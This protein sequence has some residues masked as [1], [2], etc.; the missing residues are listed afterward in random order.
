M[1]PTTQS[2]SKKTKG[3]STRT[4]T[5]TNLAIGT[6]RNVVVMGVLGVLVLII[7]SIY[8]S[9]S[10]IAYY[11][12][13]SLSVPNIDTTPNTAGSVAAAA[14]AG[15]ELVVQKKDSV[16]V[17][18]TTET[19]TETLDSSRSFSDTASV[20][21]TNSMLCPTIP[22]DHG[23]WSRK[24]QNFTWTR[25]GRQRRGRPSDDTTTQVLFQET[26]TF[27]HQV[28][29]PW[30]TND[31]SVVFYGS[32]HLRELY[33]SFVKLAWGLNYSNQKDLGKNVTV[34]GSG[35]PDTTGNR[36]LCDPHR[37][38]FIEGAYGVDLVNCGPPGIRLVPELVE[39]N[40]ISNN[41]SVAIG[42]KTFLHTPD[43]EA[44][45][46]KVMESYGPRFRHPD[47]L[48]VDVGIWGLRGDKRGGSGSSTN[49]TLTPA[50]EVDYY[51]S[52]ISDNFAS[53]RIV[54]IYEPTI[55]NLAELIL[56]RLEQLI[57]GAPL[58]ANSTVRQ[59]QHVLFRKDRLMQNKPENMPCGH[60]C[61]GPLV[62]IMAL[63]I[64][65]WM[66]RPVSECF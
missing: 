23:T 50:E 13:E 57:R 53:S 31:Q 22:T 48:L 14:N 36:S 58:K 19:S 26:M 21:N 56:P 28:P 3:P 2:I 52:W 5:T 27:P 12:P 4:D 32:S 18:N 37:T 8:N 6:L 42:F 45:F 34:V 16:L 49:V 55:N 9:S 38:G 29:Q 43:A 10:M 64:R 40:N 30:K 41:S 11:A 44:H 62:G 7:Y 47:I 59:Q 54:W 35:S 66:L 33:F 17:A 1:L 25:R 63:L 61:G 65:D 60:A 39:E 46:S 20:T 15:T 51:I 24:K